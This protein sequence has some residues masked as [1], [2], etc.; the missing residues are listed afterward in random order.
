M[1]EIVVIGQGYVGL[2]VAVSFAQAG[3]QVFGFDIDAN[4]V[5]NIN[6]GLIDSPDVNVSILL[7]LISTKKLKIVNEIP[8]LEKPATFII[9]VPTPLKADGTPELSMLENACLLISSVLKEGSLIINESTS[10]IGTL[11]N[12]IK[13]I[14]EGNSGQAN[15]KFAVAPE[16]IDPG[17]KSWNISNTP[18]IVSGLCRDAI[19]ISSELYKNICSSILVTSVPEIAESAKLFENTFR[20]V[21]IALVNEFSLISRKYGF[22]ANEA[23]SLAS[24]K[25]FGFMPFFP[26]IGVGGHC[27]PVDPAYLVYSA[28]LVGVETKLINLANETNSFTPRNVANRIEQIF[29]DKLS[30]KKIQLAGITYKKNSTDLRE[31]PALSLMS[32]LRNL[33]AI[34]TWFD[35]LVSD[36]S[37]GRSSYIDKNID[38]GL[39][40]TPHDC[41]DLSVWLTNG[42]KVLDL[43][44]D[45]ENYGWPKFL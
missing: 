29:E 37:D 10:F 28:E 36:F 1:R 31:S 24:S 33:G 40:I 12:F 15:I 20:Q 45:K 32:E 23:I 43:S 41:I 11:R 13:P 44:S 5:S 2:P 38:L 16:R 17:N 14:I 42:T 25:P 7:D 34:L 22:S 27:I 8:K 9:T 18:R 19:N 39:V 6:K 21:N 30:G 35:P 3:F 4:K 26:G